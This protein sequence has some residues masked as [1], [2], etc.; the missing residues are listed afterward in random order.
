MKRNIKKSVIVLLT[1][2]FVYACGQGN[3]QLKIDNGQLTKN[4]EIQ[5]G[6]V[7]NKVSCKND[8]SQSYAIYLPSAYNVANKYPA[9]FFFDPHAKGNL[10]LTKYKALAEKYSYILIGS[11]DSKNGLD[12]NIITTIIQN[13]FNSTLGTYSIDAGKIYMGGFSGGARV[14]GVMGALNPDIKGIIGCSA[15]FPLT[16]ETQARSF[17][18]I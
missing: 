13:L 3:K 7:V 8:T 15:S 1:L 17:E 18:W 4:N 14:A 16:K 6:I 11:N 2:M 5:K 9:I 12:W 10:P